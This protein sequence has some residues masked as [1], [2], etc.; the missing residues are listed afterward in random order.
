VFIEIIDLGS[1]TPPIQKQAP[2]LNEKKFKKMQKKHYLRNN[3]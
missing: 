3:E 1:Q 2:N